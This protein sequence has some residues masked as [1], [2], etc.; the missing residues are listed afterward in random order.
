MKRFTLKK[1]TTYRGCSTMRKII[2]IVFYTI[3][4]ENNPPLD[5]AKPDI[6]VDEER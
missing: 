6:K 1:A 2:I 5:W 4:D 3:G